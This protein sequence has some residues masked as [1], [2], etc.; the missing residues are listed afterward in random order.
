MTLSGIDNLNSNLRC[1]PTQ[2]QLG[3]RPYTHFLQELSND[4]SI[5]DV[6]VF[7]RQL[8]PNMYVYQIASKK[9]KEV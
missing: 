9:M 6:Y 2:P 5:I 4:M 1:V 8:N 7:M 3:L